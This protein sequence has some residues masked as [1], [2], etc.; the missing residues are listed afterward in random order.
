M[1][2]WFEWFIG[3]AINEKKKGKGEYRKGKKERKTRQ[4]LGGKTK[5]Y[6]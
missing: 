6:I 2:L 4:N 1:I 5:I 3:T